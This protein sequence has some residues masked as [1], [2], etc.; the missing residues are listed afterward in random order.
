MAAGSAESSMIHAHLAAYT[1]LIGRGFGCFSGLRGDF[2]TR[3]GSIFMR[4]TGET[5]LS[6]VAYII[7]GD[8]GFRLNV[9]Q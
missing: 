9:M 8:G 1:A 6:V 2:G 3:F 4:V 7:R 5:W